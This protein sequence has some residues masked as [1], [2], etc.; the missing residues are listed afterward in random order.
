MKWTNA[1]TW[2]IEPV[3]KT[4]LDQR[5]R[6]LAL[7]DRSKYYKLTMIRQFKASGRKIWPVLECRA[8]TPMVYVHIEKVDVRI[9]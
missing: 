1:K 6:E 7:L 3:D 4:F 8:D 5:R 9:E 2:A